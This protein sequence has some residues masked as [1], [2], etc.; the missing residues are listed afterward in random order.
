MGRPARRAACPVARP[1]GPSVFLD[2]RAAGRDPR[3]C[4][5]AGSV[6]FG[7]TLGGGLCWR[8][9]GRYLRFDA[10]TGLPGWTISSVLWMTTWGI[11]GWP[12]MRR[13][14]RGAGELGSGCGWQTAP[15]QRTGSTGQSVCLR[16]RC[17][18]V[19]MPCCRDHFS[20]LRHAR[21]VAVVD[22][23]CVRVTPVESHRRRAGGR[24]ITIGAEF[25]AA[26]DRFFGRAANFSFFT[27][28]NMTAPNGAFQPQVEE[29]DTGG[30][31]VT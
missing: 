8:R 31:T 18:A 10:R 22:P 5:R 4:W 19:R 6:R 16:A 7:L 21:G 11:C 28:P 9:N 2:E 27:A 20:S 26:R 15:A 24:S 25:G 30:R 1:D 14:A 17:L 23:S 29:L 3:R 13:R 12:R